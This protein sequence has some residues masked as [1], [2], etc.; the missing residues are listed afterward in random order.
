MGLDLLFGAGQIPMSYVLCPMSA[1]KHS[2]TRYEWVSLT[3]RVL[4]CYYK[5]SWSRT[6]AVVAPPLRFVTPLLL[7]SD[8]PK[9]SG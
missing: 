2:F 4:N 7:R 6:I 8:D 3:V 1:S 5:S 9:G